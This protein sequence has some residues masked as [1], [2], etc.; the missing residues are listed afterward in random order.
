MKL[1]SRICLPVFACLLLMTAC[2]KENLVD[3]GETITTEE[4]EVI[5]TNPLASRTLPSG[6]GIDLGC[7]SIDLPARLSQLIT[8]KS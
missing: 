4:P 5:E 6:D 7:F 8:W 3:N 2:Q 1:L